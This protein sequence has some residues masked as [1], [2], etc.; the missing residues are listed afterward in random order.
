MSIQDASLISWLAVHDRWS[1]LHFESSK[2]QLYSKVNQYLL[3]L[4]AIV[5]DNAQENVFDIQRFDYLP[6]R[7]VEGNFLNKVIICAIHLRKNRAKGQL[8]EQSD[9][10]TCVKKTN[11]HFRHK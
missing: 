8:I 1:D 4:N 6:S 10:T 9:K 5:C 2:I 11:L 3:S 7:V